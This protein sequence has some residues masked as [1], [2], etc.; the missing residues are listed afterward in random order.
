MSLRTVVTLILAKAI[1][2]TARPVLS[3]IN[4]PSLCI[5]KITICQEFQ[6]PDHR[7][8]VGRWA[9]RSAIGSWVY[10]RR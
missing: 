8:V 2:H 10:V 5:S 1:G 9:G 4:R 3:Q 7:R 6:V